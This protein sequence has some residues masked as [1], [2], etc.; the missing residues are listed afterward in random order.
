MGRLQRWSVDF[1]GAE[2]LWSAQRPLDCVVL[3][4]L[5]VLWSSHIDLEQV[6]LIL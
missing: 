2:T 5:S 6:T 4:H 3:G 1:R